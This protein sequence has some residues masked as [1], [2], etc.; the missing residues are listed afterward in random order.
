MT[1]ILTRNFFGNARGV[2][3][4][5]AT[6]VTWSFDATTNCLTASVGG[7]TSGANPTASVGLAVVNG[8]AG[9]FMRSDA[10]PALSVAIV[11]TWTG[12]HTFQGGANVTGTFSVGGHTLTVPITGASVSGTNTGDQTLPVGGNP[13][14][15][16]GLAVVNGVATTFMRSDAAPPLSQ[17]IS[18]TW[19]NSHAFAAG[20]NIANA[21]TLKFNNSTGTPQ[22]VLQ[23]FSDNNVYFDSPLTGGQIFLRVNGAASVWTFASTGALTC[24]GPVGVNGATPPAK[25]TGWG[26]PVAPVVVANFPSAPTTT[27]IANAIGKI[28]ADLKAFGIYGA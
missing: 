4:L 7:S 9:T 10:A 20:L 22:G 23:M 8:I 21:V 14:A 12:L 15:S 6:G 5:D 13:G 24:P 18:P 2:T 19:T 28:I 27:Q 17:A 11:P 3:F 26:V 1:A 16:V 25:V